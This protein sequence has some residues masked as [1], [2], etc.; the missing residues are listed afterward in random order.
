MSTVLLSIQQAITRYLFPIV[1][2]VG[3]SGNLIIIIVFSQRG[4]RTN[5]CS[6]Y[7]LFGAISNM[8]NVNIAIVPLIN[9][10]L[11]PPDPFSHSL[12][13]CRVRGYLIHISNHYFR[14][15]VILACIDRYAMT[16]MR[17][18]IRRWS[19][20]KVAWRAIP[21]AFISWL[22]IASHI[23]VFE[24]IQNGR[25]YVYGLYGT[26]FSIYNIIINI[27]PGC[28]MLVTGFLTMRNIRRSRMRI[29]PA[30]QIINRERPMDRKEHDLLKIVIVEVCVFLILTTAFPITLIY[31]TFT[32]NIVKSDDRVRI[33][34]F[35]NFIAQSCLLYFTSCSNF[36]IYTATSKSFRH[37]MKKLLF[38]LKRRITVRL[39]TIANSIMRPVVLRPQRTITHT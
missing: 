2:A 5:A 10:L 21:W 39:M 13:L 27:L 24:D 32:S 14:T 20:V 26:V 8:V 16:S 9:A 3:N 30:E 34:T 17:V 36:F 7:L 25:C 11:N 28:F 15:L 38:R 22:L 18:S 29:N 4:R 12:V 31:S 1:V 19:T 37:D 33:E 23:L 6:L 35:I